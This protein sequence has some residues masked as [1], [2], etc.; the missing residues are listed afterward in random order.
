MQLGRSAHLSGKIARVVRGREVAVRSL[1]GYPVE[2]QLD[3]D[4]VLETPV[5][6]RPTDAFV[7]ILVTRRRDAQL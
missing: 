1:A 7:S 6:C 5:T 2:V 3:G 4:C